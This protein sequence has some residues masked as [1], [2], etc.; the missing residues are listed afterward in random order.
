M[1]PQM[2]N[3]LQEFTKDQGGNYA[4]YKS[5]LLCILQSVDYCLLRP[6]QET[7]VPDSTEQ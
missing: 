5:G 3:F 6:R 2:L 1:L 7:T 4:V